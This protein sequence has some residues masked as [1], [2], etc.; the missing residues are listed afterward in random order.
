MFET[1]IRVKSIC[2]IKIMIKNKTNGK[3][4]NKR[5][6]FY[7]KLHLKDGVGMES[8]ACKVELTF[9]VGDTSL[10]CGSGIV[11]DVTK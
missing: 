1:A 3:C 9:T 10:L 6:F 5:N 2:M 7:I 8:T 4:G 11:K